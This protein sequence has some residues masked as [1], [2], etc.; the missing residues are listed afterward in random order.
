M[1]EMTEDFRN[2]NWD[3]ED[4]EEFFN[5]EHYF[6]IQKKYSNKKLYWRTKDDKDIL[7]QDMTNSHLQNILKSIDKH[8]NVNLAVSEWIDVLE[9]ELKERE[10]RTVT[11]NF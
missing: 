8:K 11:L 10:T 9:F 2:W 7:V 5:D 6:D 1:G 3:I 4:D